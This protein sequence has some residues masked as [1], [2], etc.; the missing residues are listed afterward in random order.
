MLCALRMHIAY[1]AHTEACTFY[2]DDEGICRRVLRKRARPLTALVSGASEEN[3]DKSERC[4]GAQ[5]VASLDTSA[6]GGLIPMPRVGVPMLFA[7]VSEGGRI[8]LV[9]T[10]NVLRFEQHGTPDDRP[11]QRQT[12]PSL[13]EEAPIP[14]KPDS[15]VRARP[16]DD[17]D[18]DGPIVP[19]V[20]IE[21]APP[22]VSD[23][24]AEM[25][26]AV[27]AE[28]P[29]IMAPVA[30]PQLAQLSDDDGSDVDETSAARTQLFR[31]SRP[32]PSTIRT[33]TGN[34]P[35]PERPSWMPST[36]IERV[37]IVPA[38]PAS[39]QR[40]IE[41]APNTDRD[42]S[43]VTPRGRGM[44]PLRAGRGRG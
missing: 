30:I 29:A 19:D 39:S 11:S 6:N 20:P 22:I 36:R 40:E 4:L 43:P 35:I 28:A 44:L 5:Y 41:A 32:P 38:A 24:T 27:T 3:G 37:S 42:P 7:Y 33:P 15:G 14:A 13:P 17:D 31:A 21:I 10:G 9:R 1:A 8:A 16:D 12:R 23:A 34:T 25:P 26:I 2:L 18:D